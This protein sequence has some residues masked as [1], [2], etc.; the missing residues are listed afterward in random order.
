MQNFKAIFDTVFELLFSTAIHNKTYIT[1]L[2]LS[3]IFMFE[4]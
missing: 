2:T 1:T 3:E 4:M